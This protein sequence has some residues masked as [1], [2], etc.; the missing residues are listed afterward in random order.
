MRADFISAN[1]LREVVA[2]IE[3][4]KPRILVHEADPAKG[5]ARLEEL[6]N[7]L[8]DADHR[9]AIF[10]EGYSVIRWSRLADFQLQALLMIV[11][12]MLMS[13]PTYI[14]ET[15]RLELYIPGSILDKPLVLR[16]PVVL[17]ERRW[18]SN[19]SAS[20]TSIPFADFPSL[21]SQ[22]SPGTTRVRP[23]RLRR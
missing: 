10:P 13:S 6:R 22:M 21:G 11:E 18:P 4:R 20:R 7:E 3:Q 14:D 23:K 2:A 9:E 12:Q 16:Q 8:K 15:G 17:C 5:G 1:C 19:C